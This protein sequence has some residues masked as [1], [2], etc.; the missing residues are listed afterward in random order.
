MLNGSQF[1]HMDAHRIDY[2]TVVHFRTVARKFS[3]G[4]LCI[5][6]EGRDTLIIDNCFGG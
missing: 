1:S 2:L 5:S 6:A 4:G 3:N